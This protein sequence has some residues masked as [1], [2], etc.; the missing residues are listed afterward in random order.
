[1][2]QEVRHTSASRSERTVNAD[3]EKTAVV[4]RFDEN[5][6]RRARPAVPLWRDR[7]AERRPS[8]LF[9]LAAVAVLAGVCVGVL[10]MVIYQRRA[11]DARP[12]R[13]SAQVSPQ[14]TSLPAP[15]SP[16]TVSPPATEEARPSEPTQPA[17]AEVQ[18]ARETPTSVTDGADGVMTVTAGASAEEQAALREA[19]D[20]WVSATNA[21]DIERQMSFYNPRLDTYYLTHGAPATSVRAEKQRVFGR[22]DTIDVRADAPSVS[23]GPDGRTATMRFRKRYQIAGSGFDNRGEVLQELRWRKTEQGWKI[24]SER[25]LRVLN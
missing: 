4:P 21:R 6:I 23:F 14:T 7:V 19:L 12:A 25:D 17:P 20:G 16:S 15:E 10:G 3:P 22:A 13:E 11:D 24:V 18:P 9:V 1:M 8:T 2:E 5:S